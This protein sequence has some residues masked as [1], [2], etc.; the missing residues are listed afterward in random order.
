MFDDLL[1]LKNLLKILGV[2]IDGQ[3]FASARIDGWWYHFHSALQWHVIDLCISLAFTVIKDEVV[4]F[5]TMQFPLLFE[6]VFNS[7]HHID[8]VGILETEEDFGKEVEA[9]PIPDQLA[10]NVLQLLDIGVRI[11]PDTLVIVDIVL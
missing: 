3:S 5:T 7:G 10:V 4:R 8:Q 1:R 2:V 6:Y 11:I 9:L